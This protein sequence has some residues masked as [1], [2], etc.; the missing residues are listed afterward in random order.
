ME[1]EQ[2]SDSKEESK[3]NQESGSAEMKVGSEG[4]AAMDTGAVAEPV[5]LGTLEQVAGAGKDA[6]DQSE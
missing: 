3:S 2:D 1:A 6:L 5:T 4:I